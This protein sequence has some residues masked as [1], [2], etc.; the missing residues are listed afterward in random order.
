MAHITNTCKDGY[1]LVG[2]MTAL[3]F[4]PLS[5]LYCAAAVPYVCLIGGFAR[6][7]FSR[8]FLRIGWSER[9]QAYLAGW[10]EAG[11][12][13]EISLYFGDLRERMRMRFVGYWW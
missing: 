2:T 11:G 5:L 13:D 3:D 4:I 8:A 7:S 9:W 1:A 6:T 12:Y 10:S